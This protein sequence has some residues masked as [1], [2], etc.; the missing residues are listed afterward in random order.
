MMWVDHW[1]TELMKEKEREMKQKIEDI[2]EKYKN[3]NIVESVFGIRDDPK[4]NFSF[5]KSLYVLNIIS[6]DKNLF[7]CRRLLR[8]FIEKSKNLDS[9]SDKFTEILSNLDNLLLIEMLA[10]KLYFLSKSSACVTLKTKYN[11]G[12]D[13]AQQLIIYM[14]EFGKPS[15]SMQIITDIK[16]VANATLRMKDKKQVLEF[17]KTALLYEGYSNPRSA[18]IENVYFKVL[19]LHSQ[20]TNLTQ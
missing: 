13:W 5:V 11:Y 6:Q 15:K 4:E 9:S 16:A 1:K 20:M 12:F 7:K 8:N 10:D 18:T 14:K 19:K 2:Q 3:L 17:I